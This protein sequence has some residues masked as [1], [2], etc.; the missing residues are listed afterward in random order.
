MNEV[1]ILYYVTEVYILWQQMEGMAE[2]VYILIYH[3]MAAEEEGRK[4]KTCTETWVCVCVRECVCV[5]VC[6][7]V[8]TDRE[9]LESLSKKITHPQLSK[10]V[11][12][13]R[14]QTFK[15]EPVMTSF[16]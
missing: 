16:I 2:I 12:P 13:T 14:N 8:K 6:V 9:H 5:C 7:C 3:Q 10:R 11:Q 1:V 15:Y 4:K